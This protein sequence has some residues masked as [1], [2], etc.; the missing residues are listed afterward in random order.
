MSLSKPKRI[1]A[2]TVHSARNYL[3][4]CNLGPIVFSYLSLFSRSF[5]LKA[6]TYRPKSRP[7]IMPFLKHNLTQNGYSRLFEN[8]R[9]KISRVGLL[10]LRYIFATDSMSLSSV[11]FLIISIHHKMVAKQWICRW[12]RG[13]THPP[14]HTHT[15]QYWLMGNCRK[16]A[17]WGI[18]VRTM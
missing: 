15:H 3:H 16:M 17:L 1:T 7:N 8:I 6:K 5:C 4:F 18:A 9:L 2:R 12:Y 11:G 10:W 14:T 13:E